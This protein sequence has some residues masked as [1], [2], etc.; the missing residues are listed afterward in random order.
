MARGGRRKRKASTQPSEPSSSE[1]GEAAEGPSS[2][3]GGEAVQGPSS[4]EGGGAVEGPSSSEE[5]SDITVSAG[6]RAETVNVETKRRAVEYLLEGESVR[7]NRHL[8]RFAAAPYL[9][10]LLREPQLDGMWRRQSKSLRKELIEGYALIES[11]QSVPAEAPSV[12]VDLCCGKG[13]ASVL[14]AQEFPHALILMFDANEA[15][16]PN[17]VVFS[18]VRYHTADIHD[19][20]FAAK[21]RSLIDAAL[22]KRPSPPR[23]LRCVAVGMHLCGSLSPRAI[24]LFEQTD[25]LDGL[26]LAPCCLHKIEDAPYAQRSKPLV[27]VDILTFPTPQLPCPPG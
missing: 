2:N 7:T 5:T 25:L 4:S 1:G 11:L 15:I 8:M 23:A 21:L 9:T 20:G 22:R 24:E 27:C 12:I 13:F 10:C 14:M 6:C 3:E 19:A 17:A 16:K 26:I 18:N